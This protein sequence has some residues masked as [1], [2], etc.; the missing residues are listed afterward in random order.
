MSTD[1]MRLTY[2]SLGLK[3]EIP[4]G[5]RQAGA[6]PYAQAQARKPWEHYAFLVT[7]HYQGR[8]LETS[9]KMGTGHA[10][11]L[12]AV[13]GRYKKDARQVLNHFGPGKDGYAIAPAPVLADV[14]TSLF[15]DAQCWNGATTFKDFCGDLGYDSD[16]RAAFAIY[17]ACGDIFK[18]LRA[19]C[20]RELYET[21]NALD[22]DALTAW[23]KAQSEAA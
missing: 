10:K 8:E 9:Y 2:V 16:S 3:R 14:L 12:P 18:R 17:E 19:L 23:A 7:V 22:E 13:Q 20:G 4:S 15:S 5:Q 21:L 1:R 11:V 6:S